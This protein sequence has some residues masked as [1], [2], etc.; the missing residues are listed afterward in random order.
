MEAAVKLFWQPGCTSCL[1]TK[2]F[3]I[4]RGVPFQSVNV[5]DD[6]GGWEELQRLGPRSVPVVSRGDRFVFAQVLD[7]V[8][9]FL[10]LELKEERLAPAALAARLDAI[11]D[12]AEAGVAALP[13]EALERT[14]PGRNRSYRAL[15]Y[16]I[17]HIPEAF[18]DALEERSTLVAE[19]VNEL[20]PDAM[21]TGPD[22]AAHGAQVRARFKR[23]WASAPDATRPME[24]YYGARPLQLVLERTVWHST[25][26][27]RQLE[28][29]LGML[30]IPVPRPLTPALLKG[31]PLPEYVWG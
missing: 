31:L 8:A 1:R 7:D 13:D 6:E 14:L 27:T 18:L 19:R 22:I 24:T 21:R 26:H 10:G 9:K 5:H 12:V 2:E 11:L 23:W 25:Q 16:H 20:P 17:F 28:M 15:G 3:L 29:V 4:R 30:G